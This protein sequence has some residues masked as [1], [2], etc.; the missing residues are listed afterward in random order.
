M[1]NDAVS[2]FGSCRC[3]CHRMR[4]AQAL[5]WCE[6]HNAARRSETPALTDEQL[7]ELRQQAARAGLWLD[8]P[9]IAHNDYVHHFGSCRCPC[10][11]SRNAAC[12]CS[13]RT[14]PQ[15]ARALETKERRDRERRLLTG[16]AR[17]QEYLRHAPHL[18]PGMGRRPGS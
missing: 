11:T 10:H 5:C 15:V 8:A 1:H 3:A 12:W 2:V 7:V 13:G 16:R 18:L 17:P 14:D 4:A 9:K 6:P